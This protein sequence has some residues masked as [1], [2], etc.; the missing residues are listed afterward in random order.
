M[1]NG[2]FSAAADCLVRTLKNVDL[3]QKSIRFFFLVKIDV[4]DID[5]TLPNIRQAN[6]STFQGSS[7]PS[8]QG[9]RP[10]RRL[11]CSPFLGWHDFFVPHR[12]TT[13]NQL[14]SERF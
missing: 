1:Q 5:D 6:D 10:F 2:K 3:L 13:R 7:E 8:Q 12:R 4:Y 14:M 11:R 9:S